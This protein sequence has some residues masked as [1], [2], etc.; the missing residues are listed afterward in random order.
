MQKP[1]NSLSRVVAGLVLARCTCC[2]EPRALETDP[3]LDAARRYCPG[4]S[5]IYLDRGDGL[6]EP[7]EQQLEAR[8]VEPDLVSDRPQ[9]TGPKE[10]ITLERATFA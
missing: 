3:S 2:A 4:T 5:L 10:R 9:R 6:F 1:N 7:T 8:T